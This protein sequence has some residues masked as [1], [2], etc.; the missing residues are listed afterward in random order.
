MVVLF[1]V[2]RRRHSGGSETPIE[3][4]PRSNPADLAFRA[5]PAYIARHDERGTDLQGSSMQHYGALPVPSVYVIDTSGKIVFDFV[6][7]D[8]KVRLPADDLLAAAHSVSAK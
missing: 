5:D 2:R 4:G 7:P 6:N 3:R 8:Y 1:G